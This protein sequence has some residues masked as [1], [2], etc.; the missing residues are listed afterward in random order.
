MN[1]PNDPKRDMTMAEFDA[2]MKD[3][4]ILLEHL[5]LWQSIASGEC[6]PTLNAHLRRKLKK[7]VRRAERLQQLR[8]AGKT[9]DEVKKEME[10]A[11]WHEAMKDPEF[12]ERQLNHWRAVLRGEHGQIPA[13]DRPHLVK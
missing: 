4:S 1:E 9:P 11:D 12:L 3:P 5:D 2:V 8:L 10:D 7:A 13:E 6:L